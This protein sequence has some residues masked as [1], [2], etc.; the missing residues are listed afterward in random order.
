MVSE[1]AP[2]Y[3]YEHYKELGGIINEE[4]YASS[5]EKS[6]SLTSVDKNYIRQAQNIAGVA[7]IELKI[8]DK[9]D[10]RIK[11][12]SVLRSDIKPENTKHHHGQ[13]SDQRLF[14]EV[15]RMLE[16]A[17]S[18][19]KMKTAYHTNRPLGTYCS[20]CGKIYASEDCVQ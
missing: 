7:G 1:D 10:P 9:E 14:L 6:R 17:G 11:L 15:L 12:Y 19:E 18:A 2:E 13:M 4:D 3:S 16:D 5:L 8:S 20:L